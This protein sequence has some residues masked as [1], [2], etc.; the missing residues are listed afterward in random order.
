MDKEHPCC[1][2]NSLPKLDFSAPTKGTISK[3]G[4]VSLYTVGEGPKVFI[5]LY[6]IFGFSAGRTQQV[7]DQISAFGYTVVLPDILKGE[8]WKESDPLGPELYKWLSQIN[9]NTIEEFIVKT[10][11]PELKKQGKTSFAVGGTCFGAWVGLKLL[12]V[13]DD[14][15]AGVSYHPSFKIEELQGRTIADIAVNVKQ[16]HLMIPG[17]NDPDN[18]KNGGEIVKILEKTTAGRIEVVEMNDVQHGFLVRGDIKNETVLKRV[19]QS[20]SLTKEFL[21]KYL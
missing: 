9:Y 2:S 13:C 5:F 19:E 20:L 16:P 17:Q 11:I 14:I 18:V 3:L 1:P 10:L 8:V 7:C 12:A 21:A 15:K 4:D 6:D